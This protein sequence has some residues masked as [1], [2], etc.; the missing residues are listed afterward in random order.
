M[1]AEVMVNVDGIKFT[2]TA[3]GDRLELRNIHFT[4]DDASKLA[5]L[6]NSKQQLKVI[7]KDPQD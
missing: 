6:I 4:A 7:I 1:K 3:N 2:T 5:Q